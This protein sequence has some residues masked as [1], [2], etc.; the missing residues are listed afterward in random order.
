MSERRVLRMA[1]LALEAALA[2]VVV[3]AVA[4]VVL[5]RAVPFVGR[6]T[7]VVDGGSMRPSIPLGA[8]VLVS[9][10]P[11]TALEAGDV[12]SFRSGP[13]QA[14]VTH[15]VTRVVHQAS[16]TYVET[17]GDA[18]AEVDPVLTP[19]TAVI[20]RV[21]WS[22]PL[23]GFLLAYLSMPS[24]MLFALSLGSTLIVALLVIDELELEVR[25]EERGADATGTRGAAVP[26]RGAP[27]KA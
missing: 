8:A 19:A 7:L 16:T 26:T 11:P 18:N 1:H 13:T 5:T 20:G 9:P 24:G 14:V 23:L 2:L 25:A 15:R 6:Q 10:V 3:L 22:F 17:K 12:V 27:S 21:D 4:S